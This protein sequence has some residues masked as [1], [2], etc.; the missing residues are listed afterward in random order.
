MP[1]TALALV[2][3]AAVLHASWNFVTKTSGGDHRLAFLTTVATSVLWAPAAWWFGADEVPRWGISQWAF[4]TASALIHVAYFLTLLRGYREADFTVVYP[5][6]RGCGPLI[7]V[8]VAIGVLGERLSPSVSGGV[9]AVCVGVFLIAGGPSPWLAAHD[10]DARRR[11]R[12]GLFWGLATGVLIAGY[13]VTDGIAV[14][15]LAMGPVIYDYLCNLIRVPL[16][17]P[18]VWRERDTLPEVLRAQW[19]AVLAIALMGPLAYILVLYAVKIA[20]L[21]HVAPAR[22]VSMLFAALIGGRLLGE[23]DRVL[24]ITGAASIVAGVIALARI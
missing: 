20:P 14:K 9:L 13:S 24:R 7:T 10:T 22:E 17:A 8:L 5:V 15:T 21:S 3:T 23:S 4:V 18:L 1:T 16:Q 6:A 19:R 12:A 11:V 2:L